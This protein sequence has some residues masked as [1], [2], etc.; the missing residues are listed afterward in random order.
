MVEL[1]E[2]GGSAEQRA[3]LAESSSDE[4]MKCALLAIATA[5]S[6][7]ARAAERRR[8]ILSR[9]QASAAPAQSTFSPSDQSAEPE[10]SDKRVSVQP[11]ATDAMPPR[12]PNDDDEDEDEEDDEDQI[13]DDE[14]AVVREPDE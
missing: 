4:R 14:P 7:T 1:K 3:R 10:S 8:W 13:G 5:S 9:L 11:D 12:D 2:L 6:E